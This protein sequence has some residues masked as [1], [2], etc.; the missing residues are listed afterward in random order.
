MW[1]RP[2][3]RNVI[4]ST[5]TSKDNKLYKSADSNGFSNKAGDVNRPIILLAKDRKSLKSFSF[6]VTTH[7]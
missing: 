5:T 4:A 7:F 2:I 6:G 3:V 1:Q